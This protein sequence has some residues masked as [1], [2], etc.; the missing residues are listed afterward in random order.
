MDYVQGHTAAS[1]IDRAGPHLINLFVW[2][3]QA[4]SGESSGHGLVGRVGPQLGRAGDVRA[5]LAQ[6]NGGLMKT[7]VP[8]PGA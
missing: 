8:P 3:D 4:A 7:P 2:P 1:L 6:P 5:S